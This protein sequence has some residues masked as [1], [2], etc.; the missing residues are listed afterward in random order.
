M[1]VAATAVNL[2]V[3]VGAAARARPSLAQAVPA[4]GRSWASDASPGAQLVPPCRHVVQEINAPGLGDL[5]CA[6]NLSR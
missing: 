2:A 4:P 6:A 1:L 5:T 3:S